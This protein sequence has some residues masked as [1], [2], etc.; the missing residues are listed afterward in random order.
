MFCESARKTGMF[1][2][3]YLGSYDDSRSFQK[4]FQGSHPQIVK[5]F[6]TTRTRRGDE[7]QFE[8]RM[9]N[10]ECRII[11]EHPHVGSYFFNELLGILP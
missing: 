6:S 10:V 7:S 5:P 1:E 4:I 11:S 2:P 9:K 8:G 3:R